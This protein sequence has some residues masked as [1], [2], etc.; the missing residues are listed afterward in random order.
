[1][2]QIW[3]HLVKRFKSPWH[4]LFIKEVKKEHLEK[5]NKQVAPVAQQ[6]GG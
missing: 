1:M 4:F 6:V 5:L 3:G 2:S